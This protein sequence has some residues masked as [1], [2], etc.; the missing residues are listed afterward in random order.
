MSLPANI[1]TVTDTALKT[2]YELYDLACLKTLNDYNEAINCFNK[3]LLQNKGLS[4]QEK[5]YYKLCVARNIERNKERDKSGKPMKCKYCNSTRYSKR[6][7]ENCI[8]EYLRG[9]F[10]KWSSDDETVDKFIQKNQLQSSVPPYI[11]E[12]I[13]FENDQFENITYLT[14]GGFSK[15]HCAKWKRGPIIDWD[16][17]KREFI[18]DGPIDVVLKS[19]NDSSEKFYDEPHDTDLALAIVSGKRPPMLSEIPD[20]FQQL[21]LKCWKKDAKERPEIEEIRRIVNKEFINVYE[22]EELMVKYENKRATE[23]LETPKSPHPTR[24]TSG[25][26]SIGDTEN[27]KI[28]S[29]FASNCSYYVCTFTNLHTLTN[30]YY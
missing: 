4:E 9:E 1:S 27:F 16:E 20:I 28:N 14:D 19:L 30:I 26:L 5:E 12:W 10:S 22:D 15:I 17:N 23:F 25:L 3:L 18:Y 6:Y 2:Y 21:I 11:L 8:R 13:P 7:C 29:Q 24:Y